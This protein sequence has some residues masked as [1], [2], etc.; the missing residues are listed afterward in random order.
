LVEISNTMKWLAGA[1]AILTVAAPTFGGG[2]WIGDLQS[3][4]TASEQAMR[5][6]QQQVQSQQQILENLTSQTGTETQGP[7]GPPG[8][9]GETPV[10]EMRATS[11]HLQWRVVG[12]GAWQTLI[13]VADLRGPSGPAG[14]D[15]SPGAA[16][17]AIQLQASESHIEWRSGEG[18]WKPLLALDVLRG[19]PGPAGAQGPVGP[20]GPAGTVASLVETSTPNQPAST[21]ASAGFSEVYSVQEDTAILVG[22]RKFAISLWNIESSRGAFLIAGEKTYLRPADTLQLEAA[23]AGCVLTYLAK[24]SVPLP[25]SRTRNEAQFKVD[26]P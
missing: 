4:I 26:C 19:P 3:K 22:P 20:A 18:S 21:A 8:P 6:L 1:G 12:Q 10:V 7:A 25:N 24:V 2:M 5:A 13:D 11:D 9:P 16:A 17:S 15:G 23:G 14:R